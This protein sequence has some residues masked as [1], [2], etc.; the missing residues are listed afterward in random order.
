MSRLVR[1]TWSTYRVQDDV[2]SKGGVGSIHRTDDPGL[3][4]KN[5]F[6]PQK[7]PSKEHLKKLVAVGRDVLFRQDKKPGDT[8]ESSVNW[9]VDIV[10]ATQ[11]GVRGVVLPIIPPELF[12]ADHGNV[13][14]LDFLVMKRARPP[15][16]TGRVALLIRM[17]EILAFVDA[18]GLVHGD[19]NGK[20]L[21][22]TTDPKIIMYLIDCDGMLPRS[23]RP[24][25][26][27]QAMGWADPRVLDRLI[28]AHDHLSDRYALA[29]AMYRGLLLTPGKLDARTSEGKWPE[30]GKIPDGFPAELGMLLR[31]G[32]AALDGEKRPA[33]QEWADAL[34]A[35]YVP[36]GAYATQSARR[37]GPD[38]RCR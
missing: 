14:T 34:V 24:T 37:A 16:A 28:P 10:P 18:K 11:A 8:P 22:W 33:P 38:E 25:A 30:P 29:L 32:L 19:V 4:Y 5:Y 15:P 27:V 20:N 36:N 21:A 3:V 6:D 13:R 35:A 12:N 7:T 23:P 31:R 2:L 1:G 17:A 9:P 26:G